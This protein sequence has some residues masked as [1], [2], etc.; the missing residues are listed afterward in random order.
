MPARPG[1]DA[2]P[3]RERLLAHPLLHGLPAAKREDTPE[4][5]ARS[6][7]DPSRG[8]YVTWKT[9]ADKRYL[10][11]SADGLTWK[12]KDAERPL[13][14]IGRPPRGCKAKK[15][16]Y[17]TRMPLDDRPALVFYDRCDEDASRRY[18]SLCFPFTSAVTQVGGIEGQVNFCPI[19]AGCVFYTDGHCDGVLLPR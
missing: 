5:F 7:W 12:R 17:A 15:P 19:E 6:I 4:D 2:G 13:R 9:E 8:A 10:F 3:L 18:K 16:L 1:S 14:L 11:E